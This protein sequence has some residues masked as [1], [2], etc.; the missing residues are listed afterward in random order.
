MKEA[1]GGT[2]L[3]GLVVAFV[4]LFTTF[5][6]VSTNY[7]RCFRIKDDILSIIEHFHGVN[8]ESLEAI[9]QNLTSIGY[10]SSGT[11]PDDGTCW[12]GY[13]TSGDISGFGSNRNYCISRHLITKES[14]KEGISGP[15]GHPESAY[16]SVAVFFRL[17]WPILNSFFDINITG[18]TSIIYNVNDNE[19]FVNVC[20]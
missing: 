17:N 4:V 6:S 19:N 1:I 14:T 10:S 11:C 3:F 16:Y 20:G 2:W 18:E 7:S 15:I 8:R 13:D 12:V 5:I 9:N